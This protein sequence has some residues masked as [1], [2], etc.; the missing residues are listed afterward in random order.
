MLACC[1]V[2]SQLKEVA[3]EGPDQDKLLEYS[4]CKDQDDQVFGHRDA[5]DQHI[6]VL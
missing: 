2:T 6:G 4:C 1:K 3:K 5:A